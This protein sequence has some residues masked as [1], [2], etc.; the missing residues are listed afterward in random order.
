M[1][2][3]YRPL[4]RPSAHFRAYADASFASN[5]DLSSQLGY[6]VFM[7]DKDDV[8]HILD[9]SSKKSKLIVRSIMAA[10]VYAFVDA[11]DAVMILAH[12]L[13]K[14][15]DQEIPLYLFTDSKQLFDAILKGK[16]TT[17]KRLMI[18][19]RCARQ[20]YK[21]FEIDSIG[22]VSGMDNPANGMTELSSNGALQK[23]M[24]SGYDLTSV[25]QFIERDNSICEGKDGGM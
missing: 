7:C 4:H 2:L 20:A 3:K 25:V 6:L 10:E 15:L 14:T 22:L 18:D 1:A 9:F 17:E 13:W 11:F 21:D 8:C 5:D 24:E 12:D 16:H 19:V 23:I